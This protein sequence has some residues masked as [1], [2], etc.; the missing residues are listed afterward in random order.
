[1]TLQTLAYQGY[2]QVD[3]VRIR[4]DLESYF[5]LNRDGKI[6]HED[7]ALATKKV[8]DV[9][10]FNLPAGSGFTAGFIGGLRSG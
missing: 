5:D 1:M 4:H 10:Q 2:I 3:H 8:M 7:R 9:L 6:N